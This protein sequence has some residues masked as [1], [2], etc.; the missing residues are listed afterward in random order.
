ML[1]ERLTKLALLG[2][3]WVLYVLLF[4]SVISISTMVERWVYFARRG[5]DLERQRPKLVDHLERADLEGLEKVLTADRTLQARIAREAIRWLSGGTEAMADAVDAEL[6]RIRTELERGTNFLGTLGNNAPFLGLF[7]TVLGVIIAFH[8]LGAA[9]GNTSAMGGVMGGIAEALV[10]TG[11]GL[12]VALPAVVGYNIIQKRIGQI[13]GDAAALVK[14]IS[15]Y[16]KSNPS[17]I[18]RARLLASAPAVSTEGARRRP[19]ITIVKDDS[20]EPSVDSSSQVGIPG[21]AQ[22]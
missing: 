11:V 18:D 3:S 14:L 20:S 6:A 17:L 7:G 1:I 5:G 13:E 22:G 10:A 19:S 16:A 2:S 12:F 8:S 21:E 4:L 9:G 15:A